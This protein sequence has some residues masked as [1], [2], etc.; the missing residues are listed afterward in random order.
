MRKHHPFLFL[1]AAVLAIASPGANALTRNW[2][3][4]APCAA[5]LQAC[6]DAS[7]AGDG[8][9]I[10]TNTWIAENLSLP[11]SI[12][13]EGA[14]GFSA[15][16]ASGFSIEGNSSDANPYNIAIRRIGLVNAHIFINHNQ[17]GTA[18]IEIR[19]VRIVSTSVTSAA[20]IRVQA[21]SG[22]LATVRIS[23][24]WLRVASPGLFDAG[25]EVGLSG[26]HGTALIDFNHLEAVGDGDGW[27]I[28]AQATGGATPTVTI[29]NNEVR[30]R[31][32]RGAIGISEGLFSST[33]STLTARVMGNAVS[34]RRRQGNGITHVINNGSIETQVINN[35]VVG[36]AFG[37]SFSRWSGSAGTGSIS[38]PVQNNLFAF[39]DRG[40]FLNPEFI[41]PIA[42]D[43]NLVFG[44]NSNQYTPGANDVVADPKLRS[45]TDLRLQT[46]SPAINQGNSIALLWFP[47]SIG[48]VDADGLRRYKN[49]AADIGAYEFGDFSLRARAD[50]PSFNGFA[51]N[52]ALV[53][54]NPNARLFATPVYDGVTNAEP[55]G[56]YYTSATWWIFN[57]SPPAAAMPVG[58]AFNVFVPADANGTFVHTATAAN[59]SGHFTTIDNSALNNQP[60][61]IVLATANWNPGGAAGVYNPHT[62]SVGYLGSNWFVLNNDF[63]AMPDGAAFNL[64]SQSPSPNA[65]VHGASSANTGGNLTVLD[66]PLL[67]GT[68]CAQV[69]ITPRTTAVDTTFDVIYGVSSL[70]WRIF[71]HN[72]PVAVGAEFNV[73]IDAGQVAACAGV[74]FGD[75][76][77]D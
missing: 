43:Y 61:Q 10:A 49:G 18:N 21:G 9:Q 40:L 58:A 4:V 14:I 42:E 56:V 2:P 8:V 41:T 45:L 35:T 76:F 16:M 23:D 1:V 70:R 28:V 11:R 29:I 25:L 19:R 44:N 73:V 39:N 77:E 71:S 64:Y 12:T 34:A 54:G 50:A 47:T 5:T 36:T 75:G 48:L 26:N 15:Q 59:T 69:H 13:L 46:G 22:G 66:H 74:L 60:N 65:Y 31:F 6:I 62:T 7:A 53:D 55:I 38:G 3:G 30:G 68:P 57:Q 72:T 27:G 37:M 67:N 24:N 63:G 32:S 51:I 20:G 52:Q 33:P 17:A